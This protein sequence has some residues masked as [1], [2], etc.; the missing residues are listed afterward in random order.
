ML[1]VLTKVSFVSAS[2]DELLVSIKK[3]EK[4]AYLFKRLRIICSL[5]K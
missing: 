5:K 1:R 3:L 4:E 2:M